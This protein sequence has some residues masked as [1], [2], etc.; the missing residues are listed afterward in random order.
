MDLLSNQLERNK[1]GLRM[2]KYGHVDKAILL[3]EQNIAEETECYSS[4]ER[5]AKIYG[6]KQM[7]D[8]QVRVL[9]KAIEVFGKSKRSDAR[10]K[11]FKLKTSLEKL[12]KQTL[13][14]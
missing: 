8:K 13:K 6:K 12:L 4:Y 2:E 10:F 5:L 11:V 14:Q 9:E 1:K 7:I 3:Y